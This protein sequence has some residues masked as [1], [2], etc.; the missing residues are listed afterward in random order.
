MRINMVSG[1]ANNETITGDHIENI[2]MRY[3]E[4]GQPIIEDQGIILPRRD[5]KETF[6]MEILDIKRK[7]NSLEKKLDANRFFNP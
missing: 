2:K 4:Q 5:L 1:I 3:T 7:V 6:E